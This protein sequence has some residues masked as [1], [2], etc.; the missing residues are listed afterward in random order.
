MFEA[1]VEKEAVVA[2]A[3]AESNGIPRARYHL[4]S[5]NGF[6]DVFWSYEI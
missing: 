4:H 3:R 2:V 5:T 6:G 1:E